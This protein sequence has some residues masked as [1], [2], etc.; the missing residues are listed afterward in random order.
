MRGE[1]AI[2]NLEIK[3]KSG[4]SINPNIHILKFSAQDKQRKPSKN[5]IKKCCLR[6]TAKVLKEYEIES[7]FR[8]YQERKQ[9][10]VLRSRQQS[11][12]NLEDRER[13]REEE[14][15]MCPICLSE[16][17]EL[18]EQSTC[19]SCHNNLHRFSIIYCYYCLIEIWRK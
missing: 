16:M 17:Y 9:I 6:L 4:L 3:K 7:L 1:Q 15:A 8:D 11:L 19:F 12:E 18:E 10:R 2:F 5:W 13:R 14:D